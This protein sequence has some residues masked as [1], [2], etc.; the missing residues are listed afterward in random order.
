MDANAG[1]PYNIRHSSDSSSSAVD[2]SGTG[3]GIVVPPSPTLRPSDTNGRA[4]TRRR[5][6]WSNIAEGGQDPP[7]LNLPAA[8]EP[9]PSTLAASEEDPFLSSVDRPLVRNDSSLFSTPHPNAS[10][11]SLLSTLGSD[12]DTVPDDDEMRLTGEAQPKS[13]SHWSRDLSV[14]SERSAGVASRARR[15]TATSPLQRTGTALKNAFHHASTRVAN[16]RG[17]RPSVRLRE[18]SE[19]SDSDSTLDGIEEMTQ[20]DVGERVAHPVRPSIPLRGRALG[21]LGPTNPLRLR[22]Y[23]LLIHPYACFKLSFHSLR[24]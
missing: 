9:G 19:D 10:S 3:L 20:R 4:Y 8:Q 21:F 12:A 24:L 22:L 7:R 13:R 11:T 5:L 2:F 17:H 23:K 14:D 6:S 18:G 16:V 1:G 15:Y